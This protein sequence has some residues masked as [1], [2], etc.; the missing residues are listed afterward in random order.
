MFR[1]LQRQRVRDNRVEVQFAFHMHLRRDNADKR[2]G[3]AADLKRVVCTHR[4]MALEF[5]GTYASDE[6]TSRRS[7][8]QDRAWHSI[9]VRPIEQRLISAVILRRKWRQFR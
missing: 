1:D 8:E 9:P 3:D 2:F 7:H 5:T 6:F 4:K